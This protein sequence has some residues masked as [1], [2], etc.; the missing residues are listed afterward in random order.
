MASDAAYIRDYRLRTTAWREQQTKVE[1][2]RRRAMIELSRRHQ[3]E[4]LEILAQQR[5]AEGLDSEP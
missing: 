3:V 1:R 5:I 2:A 4:Y